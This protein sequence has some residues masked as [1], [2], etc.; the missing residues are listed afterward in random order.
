MRPRFK[1][2]HLLSSWVILEMLLSLFNSQFHL[3]TG[4]NTSVGLGQSQWDNVNEGTEFP[5]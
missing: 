2:A 1:S 3:L 4:Q 5:L